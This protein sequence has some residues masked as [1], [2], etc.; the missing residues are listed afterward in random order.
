MLWRELPEDLGAPTLRL[1][2]NRPKLLPALLMAAVC[3]LLVI[4]FWQTNLHH[5]MKPEGIGFGLFMTVLIVGLT[6]HRALLVL[7]AKRLPDF[8]LCVLPGKTLRFPMKGAFGWRMQDWPLRETA[9]TALG[10]TLEIRRASRPR[11]VLLPAV[12][13]EGWASWAMRAGLRK[14][15][16]PDLL[17][18][19]AFAAA[20]FPMERVVHALVLTQQGTRRVAGVATT[21]EELTGL[22]APSERIEEVSWDRVLGTMATKDW[23]G[24]AT[25]GT[26]S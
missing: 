24:R 4:V 6:N 25:Q 3:D 18:M 21:A 20:P 8:S 14:R 15:T 11:V 10:V 23:Q 7:S 1:A 5:G 12:L 16:S 26:A 2:L 22:Y 13:P 17:V 9:L 19:D